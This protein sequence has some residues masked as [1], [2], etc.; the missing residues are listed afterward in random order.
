MGFPAASNATGR[1][2]QADQEVSHEAPNHEAP[3]H[4]LRSG[5]LGR[6]GTSD[7]VEAMK[8]LVRRGVNVIMASGTENGLR[9]F[10]DGTD[11]KNAQR[12]TRTRWLLKRNGFKLVTAA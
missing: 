5:R 9:R 12:P 7:Q 3:N 4:L 1:R 6:R 11:E 10:H 8:E 2:A